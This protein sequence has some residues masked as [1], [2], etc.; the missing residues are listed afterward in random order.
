MR[1]DIQRFTGHII[2]GLQKN[3]ASDKDI[4]NKKSL[5]KKEILLAF[6]RNSNV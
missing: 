4:K 3:I 5:A 1:T 2:L 6:L